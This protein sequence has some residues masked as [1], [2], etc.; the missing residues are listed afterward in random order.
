MPKPRIVWIAGSLVLLATFAFAQAKRANQDAMVITFK[1]G[2]SQVVPMS[3]VDKIEFGTAETASKTGFLGRWE[4]G[5]GIGGTF[6]ITLKPGGQASKD[7]GSPRGTWTVV[8]GEARVKWEDGWRDVI[9]K[10]GDHYE[11]V[12]Y[13]PGRTFTDSPDHIADA[14]SLDPI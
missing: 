11:K 12:A 9:R 6:I 2:H 14:K 4:V 3:E 10:A 1:D 13:R 7:Y 5:N 8:R